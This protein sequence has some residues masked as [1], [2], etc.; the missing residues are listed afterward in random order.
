MREI[1]YA[2]V[3][4]P[5]GSLAQ[6]EDQAVTSVG[7]LMN[8]SVKG[9][10]VNGSAALTGHVAYED[11]LAGLGYLQ[12]YDKPGNLDAAIKSLEQAVSTDSHFALG[13]AKLG[14]AYRLKYQMER[15]PKWLEQALAYCKKAIAQDPRISSVYVTLA[16][17]HELTG[18]HELAV[19]EFQQALDNDP[20]NADAVNGLAHSYQNAGRNGDAEAMYLKAIALRPHDWSGYNDLGNFYDDI[21]RHSD[22]IAQYQHAIELTPDN[23]VL[24]A[25]LGAAYLNTGDSGLLGKAEKALKQSITISPNYGAYANL[26]NLYGLQR[27]FAE[28]AAASESALRLNDQDY[29]VWN[30]LTEAYE[31]MGK[32]GK[33]AESRK[34]TIDLVKRSIKMNPQNAEADALL[35]A[36]VAKEGIRDESLGYIQTSLALSPDDSYVLWEVADAFEIL[37]DRSRAIECLKKALQHG[38]SRS[39]LESDPVLRG[40]FADPHFHA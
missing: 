30:N 38:L 2:D 22:A 37:G 40:V 8:V 12:R 17:I 11:Y 14:E 35:A 32:I 21:G 1:G 4:N 19:Q 13:F 10:L 28:S 5:T 29:D 33:A 18:V 9:E 34:K 24:F 36:L 26:G 7:R 31:G 6:L 16:R 27:R 39:Q 15:D 20:R 23:A 3:E 25:N